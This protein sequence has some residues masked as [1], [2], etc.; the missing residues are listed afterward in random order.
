M[1]RTILTHTATLLIGCLV[2]WWYAEST[3]NAKW[4]EKIAESSASVREAVAEGNAEAEAVD[5]QVL[6]QIRGLDDKLKQAQAELARTRGRD[7]CFVPAD[8]LRSIGGD[9][10]GRP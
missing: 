9:E 8:C 5:A 7:K 3:V 1:L 10:T 6:E 2:S 4:R